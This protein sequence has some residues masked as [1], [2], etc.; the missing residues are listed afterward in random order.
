M[1]KYFLPTYHA[2]N[3][4]DVDVTFYALQGIKNLFIDLDNTLDSYRSLI[5]NE[6]ALDLIKKLQE[7]Q[8][9]VLIV[10][11]NHGPR[12]EGYAKTLGV[13]FIHSARKPFAFK[14]IRYMKE[15]Q[16]APQET[17]LIGDQLLTDVLAAK[18]AKI[19]VL[20]TEKLVEEDQWTTRFNRLFDRPIR[21]HLK[22]TPQWREWS[23]AHE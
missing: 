14:F 22:K 1:F 18:R 5:P 23:D 15:H 13:D 4:F 7:H 20:L 8:Y 16:L 21:R 17:I 10:S 3:I 6:R 12:V 2:K 9:R 19:R 11:N